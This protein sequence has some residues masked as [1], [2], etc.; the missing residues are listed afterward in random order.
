MKKNIYLVQVGDRFSAHNKSAYL[1]YAA[2][3]IAAQAWSNPKVNAA[4][5]LKRIIFLRETPEE[6]IETLDEPFLVG[7][8]CYLW[9]FE[10]NKAVARKVKD[11]YPE[12][13]ILFG[14]HQ[15]TSDTSLLESNPF[16][17][18]LIH[19]EGEEVFEK[20]LV[21]LSEN[22]EI[23]RVPN[24]IYRKKDG[25]LIQSKKERILGTDY[26]S[27]YTEGFFDD[28]LKSHPDMGFSAI[29]ETNRGCTN[30]CSFCDWGPHETKVRMFPIERVKGDIRWFSENK[31]EYIWGADAN[32][33]QFERDRQIADWLAEAKEKNGYPLRMKVNYAKYNNLN[34]FELSKRFAESD[35]SKSTT[36]S[37]QTLSDTALENIGRRNM[38][39]NHFAGLISL[40]RSEGIPTYTELILALPG[41]TFE[42][43]IRGVGDLID[44]GQHATI[45]MYDCVL[46]PNARMSDKDYIERYQ[47]KSVS[48]PY[49]QHHGENSPDD[50]IEYWDLVV[51]TATMPVKD[52]LKSKIFAL[53]VQ[54]LHGLG[55][56]RFFAIYLRNAMDIPY[57]RFYQKLIDWA[58]EHPETTVGK[59]YLE[60]YQKVAS[61]PEGRNE[62]YWFN[63]QFG[64]VRWA[65]DESLFLNIS[66]DIENF[67]REIEPFLKSFRI[68][69]AV[70]EQLMLYQKNV[71]SIHDNRPRQL[72]LDYDFQDYFS[73]SMKNVPTELKKKKNRINIQSESFNSL[74]DYARE[75][76]WYGRRLGKTVCSVEEG[77]LTV[78]YLS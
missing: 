59:F 6:L 25:I 77:S 31:I 22:A 55:P 60:A 4:F 47:I 49:L 20:L 42:S 75:T 65:L 23:D 62:Q 29:L 63:P 54:G 66:V 9:N 44:S 5:S 8:S 30:N 26:P 67:Y 43:F 38:T 21:A 76:V 15:V 50:V 28:I 24:I 73:K 51:S 32:F 78:E 39:M 69:D 61:I 64:D 14:G 70:Y 58:F 2:G 10:Y 48:V 72:E 68:E 37:F 19:G 7:F 11:K 40:Y 45:E 52:W 41:E 3:V 17:D 36:I 13:L 34:V 46:L 33:G 56:L 1:P 18:I 27:P 35:L 12:C 71:I 16:I 53:T 57:H 74:A